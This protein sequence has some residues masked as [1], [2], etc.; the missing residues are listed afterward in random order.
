MWFELRGEVTRDWRRAYE[1][2]PRAWE[3]IVAGSFK[4][5]DTMK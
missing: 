4:Q 5:L 1:L 2:P 3:E